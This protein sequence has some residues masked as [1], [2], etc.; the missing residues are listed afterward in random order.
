MG[1]KRAR[2]DRQIQTRQLEII[3]A[4]AKLYDEGGHE[5]VTFT[6]IS[7]LA[8][9]TRPAIYKYYATKEAILLSIL[10]GDAEL[11]AK[12]LISQFKVNQMYTTKEISLIWSQTAGR[13]SRMNSLYSILYTIL[14]RNVSLEVMIQFKKDLFDAILPLGNILMQLFP[15]ATMEA[16]QHFMVQ[17]HA[18][19]MG[20]YSTCHQTSLQTEAMKTIN[21]NYKPLDFIKEFDLAIYPQFLTLE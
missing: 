20:L 12:D 16:I 2:T 11:W 7:E 14:E 6:A 3:E 1:F 18:I 9:L 21:P 4:A 15:R 17:H 5:A 8:K 13:H 10:V 19:S